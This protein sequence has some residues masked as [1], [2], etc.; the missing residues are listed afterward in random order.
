MICIKCIQSLDLKCSVIFLFFR[1]LLGLYNFR[2]LNKVFSLNMFESIFGSVHGLARLLRYECHTKYLR[3][4]IPRYYT[5]SDIICCILSIIII[6][7]LAKN[8]LL[9]L[10][11]ILSFE[12][13]KILIKSYFM[14]N[15]NWCPIVWSLSITVSL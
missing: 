9:R 3:G 2:W 15:F 8:A 1:F 14:A 11:K 7:V 12:E 10:Q 5:L 6:I 4:G 13:K